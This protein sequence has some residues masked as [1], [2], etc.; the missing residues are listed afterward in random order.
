[1]KT[2]NIFN[3][4]TKEWVSDAYSKRRVEKQTGTYLILY[5]LLKAFVITSVIYLIGNL[6]S[7]YVLDKT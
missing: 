7:Q 1:M 5:W 4:R 2:N 6:I 3:G